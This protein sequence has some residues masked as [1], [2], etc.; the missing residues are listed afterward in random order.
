MYF[1]RACAELTRARRPSGFQHFAIPLESPLFCSIS[2]SLTAEKQKL[3]FYLI[4][5]LAPA[6]PRAGRSYETSALLGSWREPCPKRP[7]R[8]IKI[9]FF[10]STYIIMN[11]FNIRNDRGWQIMTTCGRQTVWQ[12]E[13]KVWN[14]I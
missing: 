3:I 9:N 1:L 10:S 8:C 2:S 11:S 5:F 14:V 13:A 6:R 12:R 7:K 4:I